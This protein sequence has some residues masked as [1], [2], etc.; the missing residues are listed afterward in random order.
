MMDTP[1]RIQ[2]RL[3][4]GFSCIEPTWDERRIGGASVSDST[5]SAPRNKNKKRQREG[6]KDDK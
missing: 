5:F 6:K 1:T 3:D 2:T 4:Y